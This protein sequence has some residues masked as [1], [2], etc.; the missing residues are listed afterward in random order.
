MSKWKWIAKEKEAL[1][2]VRENLICGW[3]LASPSLK[4]LLLNQTNASDYDLGVT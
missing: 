2:T 3:V 4:Q 1:F